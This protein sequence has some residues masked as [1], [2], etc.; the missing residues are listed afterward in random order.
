MVIG[1]K[2]PVRMGQNFIP[3]PP[4]YSPPQPIPSNGFQLRALWVAIVFLLI[5]RLCHLFLTHINGIQIRALQVA[6]VFMQCCLVLCH[7]TKLLKMEDLQSKFSP[8]SG[9]QDSQKALKFLQQF[10]VLFHIGNF[11]EESKLVW[12]NSFLKD[13]AMQWWDVLS[14]KSYGPK[15]WQDF[16]VAFYHN[17]LNETFEM[18]HYLG[19]SMNALY[20]YFGIIQS[21]VLGYILTY[22][23][24]SL[25]DQI[26]KYTMGLPF[27]L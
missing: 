3:P 16:K 10:Y 17:L 24:L 19:K 15:T 25:I 26:G 2:S 9:V 12:V 6:I 23:Y 5:L 20:R 11:I 13:S 18:E 4:N 7:L 14:R 27:S 21:K 1:E 22:L 8:F